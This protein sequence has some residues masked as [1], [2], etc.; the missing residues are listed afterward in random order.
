MANSE[1]GRGDTSVGRRRMT[2]FDV[3]GCFAGGAAGDLLLN[4]PY[5]VLLVWKSGDATEAVRMS[6]MVVLPVMQHLFSGGLRGLLFLIPVL[7]GR[8]Y[9]K[10]LALAAALAAASLAGAVFGQEDVAFV[11]ALAMGGFSLLYFAAWSFLSVFV[12]RKAFKANV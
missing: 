12:M 8:P 7:R 5:V 11:K 9:L 4:V 2:T 6:L 3:V 10:A 1:H